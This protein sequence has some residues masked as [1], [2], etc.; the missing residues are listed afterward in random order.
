MCLGRNR[1]RARVLV[2]SDT[3]PMFIEP[4]ITRV[5]PGFSGYIWLDTKIMFKKISRPLLLLLL[6][7]DVFPGHNHIQLL[8]LFIIF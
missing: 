1:L 4:M 3:Y 5:P 8:Y 6:I 7:N 2:L